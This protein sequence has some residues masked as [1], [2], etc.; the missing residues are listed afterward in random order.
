M[1]GEDTSANPGDSARSRREYYMSEPSGALSYEVLVSAQIPATDALPTGNHSSGR[2][3]RRPS[4]PELFPEL[5]EIHGHNP[6]SR[7]YHFDSSAI[8]RR[9]HRLRAGPFEALRQ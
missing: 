3:S 6:F 7:N 4:S 2:Q 1:S 5:K 8:H 9:A